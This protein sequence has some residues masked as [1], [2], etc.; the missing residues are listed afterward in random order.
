MSLEALRQ[1]LRVADASAAALLDA[2]EVAGWTEGSLAALAALGLLRKAPPAEVIACDGCEEQCLEEVQLVGS[3]DETRAIIVC[4]RHDDMEPTE[5]PLERLRRWTVD[6][7]ALADALASCVGRAGEGR[8]EQAEEVVRG[9]AWWLGQVPVG[10]ARGDVFLARG[11]RWGDAEDVFAQSKA[12]RGSSLPV[13]LTLSETP[14]QE[15]FGER[16]GIMSLL[17]IL[18]L[19]GKQLR[20]DLRAITQAVRL[21]STETAGAVGNVFRRDGETW[22]VTFNG[23]TKRFRN[24]K[25]MRAIAYLLAHPGE[26]VAALL[27]TRVVEGNLYLAD[28]AHRPEEGWVEDTKS[29][30][31]KESDEL[32]SAGDIRQLKRRATREKEQRESALRSGDVAEAARLQ[33]SI[34]GIERL[35]ET[36]TDHR[37]RP[38]KS[39]GPQEKARKAVGRNIRD[40]LRKIEKEHPDLWRHLNST[41]RTG[42]NC[43]YKPESEMTWITQ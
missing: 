42:G 21:L 40:A 5:V 35:L 39:A 14:A 36:S 24:T 32:L 33:K 13:V 3:G 6:V 26:E 23:A 30:A 34:A 17:R 20:L 43:S 1:A 41:L 22:T 29:D 16:T 25:G 7:G 9:R 8:A 37:G 19:E 11:V 28:G 12:L 15:V 2:D 4:S 18:S 10:E 38:R 31:F 27:L